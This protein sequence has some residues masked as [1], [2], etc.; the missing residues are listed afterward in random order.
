MGWRGQ[1]GLREKVGL[2]PELEGQIQ[3]PELGPDGGHEES[4]RLLLY[5]GAP[6]KK[7]L[8]D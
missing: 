4:K 8:A 1:G 6:E 5:T 3:S 2:G 7:H